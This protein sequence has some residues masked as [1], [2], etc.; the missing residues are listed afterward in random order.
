MYGDFV[1]IIGACAG[2]A[3]MIGR[4]MELGLTI[5]DMKVGRGDSV[6]VGETMALTPGDLQILAEAPPE[7]VSP[8][9]RL[10]ARHKRVAHLL[11]KGVQPPV[12][13]AIVGLAVGTIYLLKKDRAF[14]ELLETCKGKEDII[15]D[16]F[17]EGMAG[18]SKEAMSEIRHRLE[19]EPEKIPMPQLLEI[20]K[21]TSDRTGFGPQ[22]T[23]NNNVNVQ[24][25]ERLQSARRRMKTI[26]HDS[27]EE[28]SDG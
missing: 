21:T 27:D 16:D 25:A 11:A 4:G 6:A 19:E 24:L 9:K 10:N 20:L 1:I 26:E 12:V 5:A 18:V 22:S 14:K 23:V 13:A 7:A 17:F 3:N 28:N 2:G 8:L 15:L